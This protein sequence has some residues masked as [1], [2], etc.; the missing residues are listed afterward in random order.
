MIQYKDSWLYERRYI[1]TSIPNRPFLVVETFHCFKC[2]LFLQIEWKPNFSVTSWVYV[3]KFLRT[4]FWDLLILFRLGTTNTTNL[5]NTILLLS[6]KNCLLTQ[7]I[8]T[9]LIKRL[10]L[11]SLP[12]Y[13]CSTEKVSNEQR[14][15]FCVRTSKNPSRLEPTNP[16]KF[17]FDVIGF[18]TK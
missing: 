4:R 16:Y 10:L 11:G 8:C 2:D 3:T 18:S 13:I 6:Y 14:Y 17:S 5:F 9:S 7:I 15:Y 12:Y 1:C